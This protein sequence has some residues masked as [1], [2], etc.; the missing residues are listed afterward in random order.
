MLDGSGGPSVL[1][2]YETG[3]RQVA[4]RNLR[5]S[6]YA[7]RVTATWREAST[8]HVAAESAERLR[9]RAG[10]ATM[11]DVH[12]RKAHEMTGI[13]LGYRYVG[14]P[15]ISYDPEDEPGDGFAY[16]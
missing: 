5:S 3:H 10:V 11:A 1:D 14:S 12:Q 16:S 9:V 8:S 7:A 2:S 15:V 6:E 4:D 13:E